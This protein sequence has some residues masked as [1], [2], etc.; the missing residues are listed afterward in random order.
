MMNFR[1]T[2]KLILIE[3]GVEFAGR[4]KQPAL[5]YNKVVWVR[6]LQGRW[7]RVF[8]QSPAAIVPLYLH[9]IF[10]GW[11]PA[12]NNSAARRLML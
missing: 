11:M 6:K 9:Y 2:Y 3:A 1:R 5:P 7:R 4:Q 12:Q 10:P 8:L